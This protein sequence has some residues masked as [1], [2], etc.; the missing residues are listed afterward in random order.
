MRRNS[1]SHGTGSVAPRRLRAGKSASSSAVRGGA[2]GTSRKYHA[3]TRTQMRL[4][5]ASTTNEPRQ[6]TRA[7]KTAISGG[8]TALPSRENEWVM[9][10]AKAQRRSGVHTDMARVAVEKVA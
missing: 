8:V 1:L 4:N 6:D 7:I 2:S 5:T 3:Q 10:C 9:P